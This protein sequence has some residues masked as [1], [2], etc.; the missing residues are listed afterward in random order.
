MPIVGTQFIERTEKVHSNLQIEM[1]CAA[2][3]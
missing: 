2:I 3:M 1:Q